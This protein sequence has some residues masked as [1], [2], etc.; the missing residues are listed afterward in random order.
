MKEKTSAKQSPSPAPE[1]A[2]AAQ[3]AALRTIWKDLG[4]NVYEAE[5]ALRAAVRTIWKDLGGNVYEAEAAQRAALRTIWRDLGGNVDE[6]ALYDEAVRRG[7]VSP[8]ATRPEGLKFI[9]RAIEEHD[10][11]TSFPY[12]YAVWRASTPDGRCPDDARA[13]QRALMTLEQAN[14]HLRAL[15]ELRRASAQFR[16][17]AVD[18]L[19]EDAMAAELNA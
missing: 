5:A 8:V 17:R 12:G 6:A 10:P 19:G 11:A 16:A 15:D 13:G 4:G 18:L 7:V 2:D 9:R 14:V 1:L 3:R